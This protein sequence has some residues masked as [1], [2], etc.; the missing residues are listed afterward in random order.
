M[1]VSSILILN[2]VLFYYNMRDS[3]IRDQKSQME[4]TGKEISIA[5]QHSQ[6]GAQYVEEL[7]GTQLRT[8]AL[9]ASRR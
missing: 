4:T 6:M 2:N 8:A 1:I 7:M 5:I 9:A 3:L